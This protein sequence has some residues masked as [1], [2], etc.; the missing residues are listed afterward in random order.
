MTVSA[1]KPIA[2]LYYFHDPM[3]SWCWGYRPSWQRLKAELPDSVAVVNVLGG[4]APDTD[5][6]MPLAL[7]A[8]IQSYW[9]R[10]ESELG[11]EF[12]FE[13][14]S[15]NQPRR[16]TYKACRAVI[17][18]SLQGY[19]EAMIEAIQRGYYLRA[20]NPSDTQILITLAAELGLKTAQFSA[21]LEAD[22]THQ[23]LAQQISVAY[24]APIIGFP[25][26][27]LQVA[28]QQSP[29]AVD[30]K[31]HRTTLGK[32]IAVLKLG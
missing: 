3:C 19:E 21:D 27:L 11:T 5:E 14:W 15:K 7:Q 20:I 18:A 26:L 4:L 23:Q 30:Y 6:T 1:S 2:T 9:R 10:I 8:Q 12:N 29:V 17:A 28:D 13:F 31:D 32:I 22:S 24:A 25:S 16:A